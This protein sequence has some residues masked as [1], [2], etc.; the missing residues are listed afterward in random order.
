MEEG[1]VS[2]GMLAPLEAGKS[3]EKD[4]LLEA[5]EGTQLCWYLDF[6]QIRTILDF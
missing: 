3:E 5:P 4:P 6:S 2:Q 1:G